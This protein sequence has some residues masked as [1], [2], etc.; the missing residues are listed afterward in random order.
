[1][2]LITWMLRLLPIV[3]SILLYLFTPS[4]AP[5]WLHGLFV[6]SLALLVESGGAMLISGRK[7]NNATASCSPL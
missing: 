6:L 3:S 1:M 2:H 5:W 4:S 7:W